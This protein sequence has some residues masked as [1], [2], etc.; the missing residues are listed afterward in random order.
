MCLSEDQVKAE[1]REI[2]T[3][4]NK[5]PKD[6]R[7]LCHGWDMRRKLEVDFAGDDGNMAGEAFAIFECGLD[8]DSQARITRYTRRRYEDLSGRP[9]VDSP[10][11]EEPVPRS[12]FGG[13]SSAS[14]DVLGTRRSPSQSPERLPVIEEWRVSTLAF[15]GSRSIQLTTTAIDESTFATLTTSEDPLLGFAGASDASSPTATPTLSAVKDH[16]S[17]TSDIPGQRARLVAAG[18]ST[19]SIFIWDLRAPTSRSA[20]LTNIVTPLRTIYTD[21]PQISCVALTALH[22]VHGGND[23]LVQA[24]DPLASTTQPVRTLNSRF[25]SRARRRLVQAQASPQGVGINLF[26]AG[27]VVLDPDP[28]CLRGMVSLGT[29][30]RYWSYSSSAADAYKGSK[31]RGGRRS[32]RGSNNAAASAGGFAAADATRA[33]NLKKF[34]QHERDEL[35]REKEQ[36]RKEEERLRGRFGMGLFEGSEEEMLAYA[37][38]L[39]QEAAAADGIRRRESLGL[40]A[41][42]GAG[43]SKTPAALTT[44]DAGLDADLAIAI[45]LSK[46]EEEARMK[47][48][49]PKEE[50]VS[51]SRPLP[52]PPVA[53]EEVGEEEIDPDLAEA[54][55]LSEAEARSVGSPKGKGAQ[56]QAPMGTEEDEELDAAL[57]RALHQ[58]LNEV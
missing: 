3:Y 19:G 37:A 39:S 6:F 10:N 58:S 16:M 55:R 43:S 25:S 2:E 23:G 51:A 8:E 15:D 40:V 24:W 18:T 45:R 1:T 42:G 31:R 49:S 28:T 22:L 57:A 47:I 30:L 52:P 14:A 35:E 38:M 54:I 50:R 12:L 36:R 34:I 7:R 48:E 5:K 29:H 46:E 32:E 44:G 13:N 11:D 33:G 21:S 26:A 20:E 9:R 53:E 27:A 56:L 17:M 4:L 41:D